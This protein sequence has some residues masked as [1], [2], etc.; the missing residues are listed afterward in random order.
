[1]NALLTRMRRTRHEEG[2]FTLIE[3]IITVAILGIIAGGISSMLISSLKSQAASQKLL[4]STIAQQQL[5]YWLPADMQSFGDAAGDI[6]TAASTGQTYCGGTAIPGIRVLHVAWSDNAGATAK[7]FS[8]D[9]A[10]SIVGGVSMLTRYACNE[11]VASTQVLARG[12]STAG[13]VANGAVATYSG[14][15]VTMR[16]EIVARDGTN[17]VFQVSSVQRRAS[18]A[19]ALTGG[20]IIPPPGG[21]DPCLLDTTVGPPI[22]VTPST[23]TRTVGGTLSVAVL[24]TVRTQG[25]CGLLTANLA[26]SATPGVASIVLAQDTA[27]ID[28]L[29]E[30][31]TATLDT[32]ATGWDAGT[33]TVSILDTGAAIAGAPT[34]TLVVSGGG[35]CTATGFGPAPSSV[36]LDVDSKFNDKVVVTASGVS[37]GCGTLTASITQVS[38]GSA[39]PVPTLALGPINSVTQTGTLPKTGAVWTAGLY[40][41]TLFNSGTPTGITAD[42]DVGGYL[43]AVTNMVITAQPAS[44]IAGAALPDV[45]VELRNAAGTVANVTNS[46]TIAIGT[47]P[48]GGTL[49]GIKTVNAVN[50]IATFN[51]LSINKTGTGYTLI[52]TSGGV[53][54]VTSSAFNITNGPASRVAFDQQPTNAQAG[55]IITPSVTVRLEDQFGNL[56]VGGGSITLAL[57]NNPSG[58]VLAGTDTQ[59]VVGGIATFNDLL[60]D[61]LGTGYRLEASS[62]TLTK[63]TSA[64][65]NITA[66]APSELRFATQPSNTAAAAS[67]TTTVRIE[68][69][70]GNL[71]NSTASVTLT[72]GVN[73]GSGSLSGTVTRPAVAGVATF[74]GLSIDKAGVGY[75]LAAASSGLAG[76]TSTPFNITA[77]PATKLLFSQQPSSAVAGA[78]ITPGVTVWLID[79]NDNLT[80][81]SASVTMAIGTNAGGG[82]LSG[83]VTR[84]AVGGV[85]TFSDLSINKVGVGYTLTATSVA[86]TGATSAGFTISAGPAAKLTFATSPPATVTAGVGINPAVSVRIEDAQGNLTTSTASVTIGIGVNPGTSTLGGTT[87]APASGG[88]A[89]FSTLTLNKIGTG[90]TLTAASSGLTGSTSSA[91]NVV[92]GSPAVLAFAQQPSSVNL[93]T[94]ITPAVTV[95]IEDSFGNITGSTASI[96][97][98]IGTNPGTATLG[99]TTPVAAVNGLATFSNLSLNRAGTGYTLVASSPGLTSATSNAF[100]VTQVPTKVVFV[101]QPTSTTS[102][103]T[104]SPAITVQ[105]QDAGNNVV[106]SSTASITLAIASG[107]T[108]GVFT[109]TSTLTVTATNGVATFSN[110][111]ILKAGTY[112]VTATSAP[113]TAATSTSFTINPGTPSKLTFSVQPPASVNGGA[114]I[115]PPVAVQVEDAN[116]NVVTTSTASIALA[117]NGPAGGTLSG[118]TPVNAATGVASFTNLSINKA[119][120]G[121]TL[122]ASSAGLT[123]A[124]STVINVNIGPAAKL[125]FSAQPVNS[126][127]GASLGTVQVEIQDAG[128]NV[129]NSTA[130]VNLAMGTNTVGA[131]LRSNGSTPV[132]GSAASGV[133]T[134]STLS[135]NRGGPAPFTLI[136]S[137]GTLTGATSNSF[138]VT[139][140][141]APTVTN[142]TN[143]AP[144][145]LNKNITTTVTVTGA[146]FITGASGTTLTLTDGSG[147]C[148]AGAVNVVSSTSITVVVTGS[149]TGTCHITVTNPDAQTVTVTGGINVV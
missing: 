13:T 111:A 56:A 64:A 91:F 53:P 129:V 30:R 136:A 57:K 119:G 110:L 68:D 116:G 82:T 5:A 104:V 134:F 122:V 16:V 24:I 29:Y 84:G 121:Y 106:T 95:R 132:S 115:A 103:A 140:G 112:T 76:A 71:T 47:N 117:L 46:V 114:T 44:S 66:G 23:V 99:G 120:T 48:A 36:G 85:A 133:A 83:N 4:D 101:Q 38:G 128:G 8:A 97:M 19:G 12:L 26:G 90:Y 55:A 28:P 32:A 18:G 124:T 107:P 80:T 77:G 11:G 43:S 73:A 123:S 92:A 147:K 139:P 21:S 72:I 65:F 1:M 79:A 125:V 7:N 63:A 42:L 105:V 14:G 144:R 25:A 93:G 6:D 9:Y 34:A 45:I 109:P 69:A 142:P 86:L 94:Q 62:G 40:R 35:G 33:F 75:T 149:K 22:T 39:P 98:S 51:N 49:S 113:L 15:I 74:T 138:T 141:P 20:G 108:G 67:F 145:T 81:S 31:W 59:P 135:L 130:T 137:S 126:T 37:A 10:V 89:S 60:I 58:G 54:S 118:T 127:A 143:L 2:G 146:N 17:T 87:S 148:S 52:V 61:K 41:L 102:G 96:S 78:V 27:F 50:G 3:L 88:V 100:N 131:V 70:G